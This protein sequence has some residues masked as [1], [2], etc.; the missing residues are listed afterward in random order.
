MD[1]LALKVNNKHIV[2]AYKYVGRKHES[3]YEILN[4]LCFT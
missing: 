1:E 4:G 2:A 3:C